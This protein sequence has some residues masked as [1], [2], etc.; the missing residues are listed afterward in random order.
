MQT[1]FWLGEPKISTLY[2]CLRWLWGRACNKG[3]NSSKAIRRFSRSCCKLY[4]PNCTETEEWPILEHHCEQTEIH[5]CIAW[6]LKTTDYTILH[7]K[8]DADVLIVKTA[9]ESAKTADTILVMDDTDLFNFILLLCWYPFKGL[10]LKPKPRQKTNTSHIWDITKL[11]NVLG[12]QIYACI[13][14]VH[15]L[16]G[17][18]TTSQV[19][20]IGKPA[21]LKKTLTRVVKL[22]LWILL[23]LLLH[24]LKLPIT[25][26]I[27]ITSYI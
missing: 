5:Q 3:S 22:L 25:I 4:I 18:D 27:T 7:A 12:E 2:N 20:G 1:L 17:C 16:L 13:L 19:H 26:T 24:V 14:F 8:D 21:V 6:C 10:Y 11:K 23:L 15:A 9:V